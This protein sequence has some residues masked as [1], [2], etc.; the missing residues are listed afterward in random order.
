[1]GTALNRVSTHRVE[2]RPDGGTRQVDIAAD[3]TI[4]QLDVAPN[5]TW[6]TT[7]PDGTVRTV[8][9]KPDPRFAM[10]APLPGSLTVRLPSGLTSSLTTSRTVTLSD[11]SNLFSL[12]G[13]TDTLTLNGR[14]ATSTYNAATRTFTDRSPANRLVTSTIDAQGRVVREQV[15]SLE[16]IA[17][18]YDPRGRLSTVTQGTG[19]SARI[20]SF[21]YTPEGHLETITDPL[22]RTVRFAYDAAGR[23]ITQT[24]P[25]LREIHTTYDANGNVESITPPTRPAHSFAYTPVDLESAYT[26]PDIGIG[27]VATT[28]TYNRDKQLTLVIRPDG[29]TISLDYDP[30]KGRLV[31]MTEPRGQTTFT[32]HP[33]SGHV[34]SILSPGGVSLSYAYDGSLVTGATWAGEVAGSVTR[35]YDT[36]FRVATETVNGGSTITLQ[37]GPDSLLTQAGDLV[38]TRHPQHGL[39]TGTTLGDVTDSYTYTPFGELDTYQARYNGTPIWDVD[40]TRDAVGRITQK[41]ETIEGMTTTTVYGYDPAG[42]LTDVTV[43]GALAA[44]YEYDA[45]GNRLSAIRPAMGTVTALYDS[46]DR[47]RTYGATTYTYTAGGELEAATTAAQTFTYAYDAFGNL[48]TVQLP[49]GTMVEYVIDGQSRRIG[50]KVNG[51]LV[52]SFLYSDQLRPAVEIVSSGDVISRFAYGSRVNVPDYM[53]KAGVTYRLLTDPTGSVRLVVDAATGVVVQRL[54][55]DEFDH[56]TVDTNPGFQPF[57]FAGGLYDQHTGF[58]R[59]GVRDYDPT[60]GRWTTRDPVLFRGGSTN[61]YEYASNDPINFLDSSGLIVLPANPAGLPPC[62]KTDPTHRDPNGVRYRH[63]SGDTLDW[64]PAQPGEHGE[65]ARSHWHH[66]R[67]KKTGEEHLKPGDVIPGGE[68]PEEPEEQAGEAKSLNEKIREALDKVN[69]VL[70]KIIVPLPPPPYP[71]PFPGAPPRP[72][73]IPR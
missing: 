37:Y 72:V 25:D 32:Y 21:T 1:V 27:P 9:Q 20:S 40:Y 39:L 52:Q 23:V 3:G 8:G 48:V 42:R 69:D 17:F 29:Q 11:P 44:H 47:L 46:Q 10:L 56:I 65:K 18:T 38:L 22:F 54:D 13:T 2:R 67:T 53:L 57:G 28:Y 62:W 26:P 60:T 66:N 51:A 45:N 4:T 36:D 71:L 34:S 64:H 30:A 19:G 33:T 61:L 68:C 5:A 7:T 31:S 50:K 35:T 24:L 73:P 14:S 16:P 6:T 41:V 58:V 49:N 63:P 43:D 12:T 15:D 70:Q 59:F 55:Y